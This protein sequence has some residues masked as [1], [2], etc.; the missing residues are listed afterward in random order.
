[1][2]N[3]R[4]KQGIKPTRLD[5]HLRHTGKVKVAAA[6]PAMNQNSHREE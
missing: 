3:L 2:V 5:Y 4:Q 1:M 6:P